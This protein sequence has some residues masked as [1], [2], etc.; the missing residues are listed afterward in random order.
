M[1]F[2]RKC[3]WHSYSVRSDWTDESL[4]LEFLSCGNHVGWRLNERRKKVSGSYC[5]SKEVAATKREYSTKVWNGHN[6]PIQQ[7][8][9]GHRRRKMPQRKV[10]FLYV[11]LQ[12]S[13]CSDLR[14]ERFVP[15]WRESTKRS[16]LKHVRILH[17]VFISR[18]CVL[19]PLL[20]ILLFNLGKV[21]E[22]LEP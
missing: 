21:C 20:A 3:I 4:V 13:C 15:C 11:L 18:I 14:N 10:G 22:N 17:H 7:P 9:R 19:D 1:L 5:D 8:I 12:K 16:S 6:V 2:F